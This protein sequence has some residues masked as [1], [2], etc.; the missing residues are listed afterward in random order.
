[1]QFSVFEPDQPGDAEFGQ[2]C[3]RFPSGNQFWF[4]RSVLAGGARFP[5]AW[6]PEPQFVLALRARG[7]RGVFVPEVRVGHRVQPE[8]IDPRKF[9]QRALKFGRE[10]AR[11]DVLHGSPAR[12]GLAAR[13]RAGLRPARAALEL[14]GWSL[15][16]GLAALRPKHKRVN[17][18]ARALWGIAYCKARMDPSLGGS[19]R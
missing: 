14:A 5:E 9:R 15:L 4:R 10:M 11:L 8:L 3:P 6:P 16:W 7:H 17:A 18:Q 19:A 12:A 1:M 2:G 13:L